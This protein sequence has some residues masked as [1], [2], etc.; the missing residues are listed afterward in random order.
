[1]NNGLTDL[2]PAC[3]ENKFS[4]QDEDI[5]ISKS[6]IAVAMTKPCRTTDCN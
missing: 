3:H 4:L 1:M 2:I 5:F 6:Y